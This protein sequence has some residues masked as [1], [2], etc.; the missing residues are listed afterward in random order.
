MNQTMQ[1]I[2]WT[3]VH[4][5]W[6]GAAIAGLYAV[7][8]RLT[9]RHS[10]HVRYVLALGALVAML[11]CAVFTLAV[12]MTP[13]EWQRYSGTAPAGLPTLLYAQDGKSTVIVAGSAPLADL[14]R[15]AAALH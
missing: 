5:C 1:S 13:S 2:G 15:L 12:E 7:A 8:A 9:A 10:S 14:E 6:Q 11:L 3:L 4:F